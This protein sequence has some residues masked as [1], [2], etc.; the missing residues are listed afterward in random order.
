MQRQLTAFV[1]QPS[2]AT[3]LAARDAVLRDSPLPIAAVDLADLERLL[4]ERSPS[5][6]RSH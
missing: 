6:S 5:D 2:K 4:D 1:E 3:Y